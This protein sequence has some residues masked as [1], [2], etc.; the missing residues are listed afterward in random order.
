[1]NGH[2]QYTTDRLEAIRRAKNRAARIAWMAGVLAALLLVVLLLALVDYGVLLSRSIRE[3]GAVLLAGII[4]YAAIR[5]WRIVRLPGNAKNIA[6]ELEERRPE[7]GCVVSTAAEYLTGERKAAQDYEPELVRTLQEEAAKKLRLLETPWY[8]GKTFRAMR[9]LSVALGALACFVLLLPEGATAVVRVTCPW[10]NAAYTR[11]EVRPG[12]IEI[13]SGHDLEILARFHGRPPHNAQLIWQAAPAS[14]WQT[15]VLSPSKK[16][17][18]TNLLTNIKGRVTYKVAGGDAVSPEFSISTF[19]PP[20]IR[21]L[22]AKVVFPTYTKHEPIEETTPDLRV[23]RGSKLTFHIAAAGEITGA[24]MRFTNQP[25]IELTRDQNGQWTAN[26]TA[27]TSSDYQIELTDSAGHKGGNET[28]YHLVVVPDEAPQ[29]A[30]IDP[31]ADIRAGPT[32]KVPL[33]ISATDDFGVS[34]IKLVFQKLGEPAKVVVCDATNLNEPEATATAEIDLAPLNLKPYEVVAYHAE[35]ADNNT[36]DG[37]GIGKSPVYF[38]EF[39]TKEEPISDS[40]SQVQRINLLQLEK[41]IIAATTAVPDERVREKLPDVAAIQRQTKEYAETFKNTS[42]VLAAA[43]PAARTEFDAALASMDRSIKSLDDV[44]RD[45]A[46]LS[47]DDALKHLYQAVKLF[48]ELQ[49]CMCNCTGIKIVAEAIE[50]K[51][52]AEQKKREQELPKII[53]R[54]KQMAA[55]QAKLNGLYRKSAGVGK[56]TG[57]NGPNGSGDGSKHSKDAYARASNTPDGGDRAGAAN[58]KVDE[59][60]QEETTAAPSAEQKQLAEEASRLAAKL[61]ELAGIDPRISNRHSEQ[62]KEV[63]DEMNLAGGYFLRNDFGSAS[64]SGFMAIS[65]VQ[66]IIG[67]LE[68][69]SHDPPHASDAAAEEYPKEYGQRISDYLRT[70]SYQK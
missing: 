29:V 19:V 58:P 35:A 14:A 47:E 67:A 12:N 52:R 40:H 60:H 50:K 53:A 6:L 62:M 70:L 3:G 51:K 36:M 61:R 21:S 15:V 54:A 24:K 9:V 68:I 11:V 7:L 22:S 34:R 16:G 64:N 65:S 33:Q 2:S 49:P 20:E 55:A 56:S 42:P 23:V 45:P 38:I 39:T 31:D 5:L 41:Q 32:N 43:P 57:Q 4:L 1:M 26:V 28:P 8:R 37:P 46:L 30:I 44:Q 27:R 18:C 17:V 63:A 10:A 69:L 59:Q 48:P 66:K 25:P 13:P